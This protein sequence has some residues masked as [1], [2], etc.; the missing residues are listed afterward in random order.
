MLP[1]PAFLGGKTAAELADQPHD[2]TPEGTVDAES[3]CTEF[4]LQGDNL[5]KQFLIAA[6]QFLDSD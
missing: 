3:V 2:F 6:V 4:P 1:D 5:A